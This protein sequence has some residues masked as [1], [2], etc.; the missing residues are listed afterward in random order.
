[1]VL[2]IQRLPMRNTRTV[3]IR[4]EQTSSRLITLAAPVSVVEGEMIAV[5]LT[6]SEAVDAG[7][8]IMVELKHHRKFWFF[9]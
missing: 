5:T 2:N 8:T 7:E 1:M 9:P 4:E 6:T 3:V